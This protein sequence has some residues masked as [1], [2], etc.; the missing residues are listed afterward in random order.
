MPGT[1]DLNM[2]FY[3]EVR[4][5]PGCAEHWAKVKGDKVSA[6][7]ESPEAMPEAS[8][9]WGLERWWDVPPNSSFNSQSKAEGLKGPSMNR[10]LI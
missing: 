1:E 10:F 3:F 5:L 2:Y 6:L 4:H 9:N 7:R 8:V